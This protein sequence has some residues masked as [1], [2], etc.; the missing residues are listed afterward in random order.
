MAQGPSTRGNR[1]NLNTTLGGNTSTRLQNYAPNSNQQ[2][3][4][5]SNGALDR[6]YN[7]DGAGNIIADIR[8]GEWLD[9]IYNKR[10]RLSAVTRNSA[11]WA[12]YSYNALEQLTTRVSHSPCRPL[13]PDRLYLRQ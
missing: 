8:T 9:Y 10:N 2:Y 5:Y 11:A 6:Y 12:T 7:Y 1:I 13:R 3:N 4:V